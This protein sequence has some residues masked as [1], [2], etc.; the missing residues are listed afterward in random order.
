M[1]AAAGNVI[2]NP[3]FG[4]LGKPTNPFF[5]FDGDP[6]RHRRGGQMVDIVK[7]LGVFE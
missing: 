1:A 5:P 6:C 4:E 7:S 2:A 3:G